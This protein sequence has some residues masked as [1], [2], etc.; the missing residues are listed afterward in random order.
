MRK[1]VM[2]ALIFGLAAGN[3]AGAVPRPPA[4]QAAV[5]EAAVIAA[6]RAAIAANY[7]IRDKRAALDAVLAKGLASGRYKGLG[8]QELSRRV[9]EDLF[10]VAQ[11]KH[12]GLMFEPELSAQLA[13]G[14]QSD[15]IADDPYFKAFAR[16][17]NHG[18]TEMRVLEGN[19][20]LVSYEGFV[21]TGPESAV[22][23]DQAA[24]F[25][26]GG[27]AAIIDLR[28]NGGGSPEAVR[29]LASYFVPAGTKLVTFH[30]RSEAPRASASEAVPG[31]PI[32]GIPVYVLTSGHSASAAEEFASH[33]ARLGFGTLI[34]QTTAGAAYRNEHYPVPGGFVLSVSIGYPELPG[35]GNWEGKGV[36]PAIAAPEGVALERALQ[37][38][39]TSLAARAEGPRKTEL[40]WTAA[41]HGARVAPVQPRLPLASYAGRY[42][43][44]SVAVDGD[45]LIY[46]RDGGMR[47][48]LVA[49]GPDLFML[50]QDPRTQVRFTGSGAS[51][52]GF[53]LERADGSKT[54]VPRD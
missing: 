17:R 37:A 41:L 14:G 15:E 40:E 11:D 23:L 30:L 20:R 39:A 34:G 5:D 6:V 19:I 24:A 4:A 2:A 26:R 16:S 53:D 49:I 18:V 12:L 45:R 51:V 10:A 48:Q 54:P 42:G 33:V 7:V 8:P 27:D 13:Q 25:L 21:W 44:R 35:G 32:G 3:P 31:G 28:R 43:V 22:A 1:A 50:E 52:T 29:R 47:T 46:Q 38:A 9:N 36:A